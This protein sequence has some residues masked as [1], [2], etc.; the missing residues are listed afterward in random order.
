VDLLLP[1]L[2]SRCQVL[3]L[4]PVP[5]ALIVAA[6]EQRG[7]PEEEAYLIG[8]LA[9]GRVGWA[10]D[11]AENEEVLAQRLQVLEDIVDLADGPYTRR[12]AWAEQL[13]R[14]PERI[15][16]VLAILSSWWRDVLLL[17]SGSSVQVANVD[18]REQLVEWAER[19]GV[20]VAR[21]VLRSVRDTAWRLEHN[22]NVRLALEV[23]T[24]DMPGSLRTGSE[25]ASSRRYQV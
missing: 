12:F 25:Y 2:V 22:V 6:L 8:S 5:T 18:C 3:N 9:Q 7:V 20:C 17:A 24:L 1:T 11:A 19:H 15:A 10:L 4:R 13:S 21:D 16:G 23:L 14:Q